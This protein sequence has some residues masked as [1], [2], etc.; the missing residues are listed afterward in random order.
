ME[1]S[2]LE[3]GPFNLENKFVVTLGF[4]IERSMLQFVKLEN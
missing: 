3:G 1:C 2:H 4:D